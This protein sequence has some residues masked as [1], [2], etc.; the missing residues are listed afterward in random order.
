MDPQPCLPASARRQQLFHHEDRV[1]Q[2]GSCVGG[3]GAGPTGGHHGAGQ[4]A[5]G[6]EAAALR[7]GLAIKNPPKKP[8]QKTHQ[9]THPKKPKK[10]H[11]K[12]PLKCF[13]W[14]FFKIFKI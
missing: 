7:P 9:K 5:A 14:G 6:A 12:K 3:G 11:L 10:N 4:D 13:F 2:V 8:T 1:H